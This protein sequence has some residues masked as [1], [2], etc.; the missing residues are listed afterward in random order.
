M[1]F[2]IIS[3]IPFARVNKEIST[4]SLF[5]MKSISTDDTVHFITTNTYNT[6]TG[7]S[8]SNDNNND[9]DNYNYN[10]DLL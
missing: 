6:F 3:W 2:A 9:N 8:E 5:T 1:V 10:D 7:S 4:M